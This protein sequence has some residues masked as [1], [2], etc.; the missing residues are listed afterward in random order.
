MCC[1]SSRPLRRTCPPCSRRSTPPPPNCRRWAWRCC[2]AGASQSI[3]P[4]PDLRPQLAGALPP[5]PT[6]SPPLVPQPMRTDAPDTAALLRNMADRIGHINDEA[7]KLAALARGD[8][9][10]ELSLVRNQWQL[11]VSTTKWSWQAAAR[12]TG[13]ARTDPALC[14]AGHAGRGDGLRRRAAPALGHARILD[15]DHHRRRDARQPG[16]DRAA[17]QC[18]RGRHRARLPAG[19]GPAR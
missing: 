18:A 4:I 6:A 8:V 19:D 11:F 10:P 13:L 15:I 7:V 2:W 14:A 17:P 3:R 1:W 12:A 9:A 16:A 5:R